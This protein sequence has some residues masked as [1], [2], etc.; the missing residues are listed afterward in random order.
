M[1]ANNPIMRKMLWVSLG[2]AV[3]TVEK[4][5]ASAVDRDVRAGLVVRLATLDQ[6]LAALRDHWDMPGLPI[7]KGLR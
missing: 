4:L 1:K 5:I 2:E 3:T 7:C 6:R